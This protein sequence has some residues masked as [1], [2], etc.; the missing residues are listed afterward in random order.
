M[1]RALKA[2][3]TDSPFDPYAILA[4]LERRRGL[5]RHRL[6]RAHR[7]RRRG[8]TP[9]ASTS[10][11][12]CARQ[13]PPARAG[14]RG[15]RRCAPG[16]SAGRS[17]RVKS[18]GAAGEFAARRAS[19]ASSPSPQERAGGYDDLRALQ[20][21]SRSARASDVP[22]ASTADLARMLAALG[23]DPTSRSSSPSAASSESSASSVA[24]SRSDPPTRRSR[25]IATATHRDSRRD[26]DA[27]FCDA[28]P[29]P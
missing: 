10:C 27:S 14:A 12:P 3:P 21:A 24:S 15:P 29:S 1:Q 28:H 2:S 6:V 19:S 11:R 13:P 17:R 4:A 18:H 16:G 26:T 7:P 25:K 9:T 22:I 8:D 20:H 5:R 23:R